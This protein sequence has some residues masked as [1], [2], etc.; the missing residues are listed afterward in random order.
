MPSAPSIARRAAL[1]I[2]LLTGFYVPAIGIAV[3]LLGIPNEAYSNN[4]RLPVKLVVL[5]VVGAGIILWSIL[6]RF[7]RFKS[8]GPRLTAHAQPELFENGKYPGEPLRFFFEGKRES[9][10]FLCSSSSGPANDLARSGNK[11]AA[12]GGSPTGIWAQPNSLA[13]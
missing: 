1:A 6:P 5:S 13:N 8:L 12:N 4:I 2:A 7:D 9:N 11:I 3:V 10:F